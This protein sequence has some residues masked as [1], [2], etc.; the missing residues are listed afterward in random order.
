MIRNLETGRTIEDAHAQPEHMASFGD[1]EPVGEFEPF[2]RAAKFKLYRP[3]YIL[4]EAV[5]FCCD[6]R[7]KWSAP[8]DRCIGGSTLGKIQRK[9]DALFY[10][11]RN[12]EIRH[13]TVDRLQLK[14]WY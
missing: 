10:T 6:C 7:P 14:K 11:V 2:K 9:G 5:L 12:Q 13:A 8:V 4:R 1:G 3:M